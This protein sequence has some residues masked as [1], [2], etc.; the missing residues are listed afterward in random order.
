[1]TYLVYIPIAIAFIVMQT[2]VLPVLFFSERSYDLLLILVLFLGFY[3]SAAESIPV[4]LLLGLLSDSFSGGPFGLYITTYLWLF[5]GVKIVIPLFHAD[6]WIVLFVGILSGV[7]LEHATVWLALTMRRIPWHAS[8]DSAKTA[9]FQ[10]V[11]ALITGPVVFHMLKR[12]FDVWD[13]WFKK[14][15]GSSLD[16]DEM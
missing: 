4:V 12:F 9:V 6:S 2:V 8:S 13:M 10:I 16:R 3:R 7:L 15:F 14:R 5:V 11:W 1:M